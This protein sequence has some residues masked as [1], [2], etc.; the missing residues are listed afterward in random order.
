MHVRALIQPDYWINGSVH[1]G[2]EL[3][4]SLPSAPCSPSSTLPMAEIFRSRPVTR[5][6]VPRRRS[7]A[8]F[9]KRCI[10]L[11]LLFRYLWLGKDYNLARMRDGRQEDGFRKQVWSTSRW[12]NY[13]N[14]KTSSV[15]AAS[16]CYSNV[17]LELR[18]NRL[19]IPG[20][21]CLCVNAD[22]LVCIYQQHTRNI[23]RCMRTTGCSIVGR[24][25]WGFQV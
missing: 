22:Q 17:C 19:K 20:T 15:L 1:R 8:A 12:S 24:K 7:D 4:F 6:D 3:P 5:Q 18:T 9:D 14:G 13:N 21:G 25:C 10:L 16:F 2:K 23:I 11:L